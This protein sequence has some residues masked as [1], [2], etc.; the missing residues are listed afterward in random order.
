MRTTCL[1]PAPRVSHASRVSCAPRVSCASRALSS[2]LAG[3]LCLTAGGCAM[4]D[5]GEPGVLIDTAAR[6]QP[7]PGVACAASID[8]LHWDVVTPAVISVGDARGELRVVCNHPGYRT[9]ELIFRPISGTP[10]PLAGTRYPKR[11]TLDMNLP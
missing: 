6:G 3:L 11:L 7:L 5:A 8:D 9:S 1:R 4:I 10:L 2:L